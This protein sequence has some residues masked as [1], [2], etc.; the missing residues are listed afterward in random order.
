MAMPYMWL[1]IAPASGINIYKEAGRLV[2][3]ASS[4]YIKLAYANYTGSTHVIIAS[5]T[6]NAYAEW[7]NVSNGTSCNNSRTSALGNFYY[8]GMIAWGNGG[9]PLDGYTVYNGYDAV[10]GFDDGIWTPP[11]TLYPIAYQTVNADVSDAPTEAAI[12]TTVTITPVYTEGYGIANPN[13]IYVTNN[14]IVIPSEYVNGVLTFTMPD[15]S[16]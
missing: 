16:Q 3:R 6:R 15:P 2:G 10:S 9:T 1:P 4:A 7:V 12:N 14:G 13:N 11:P 5:S 8:S